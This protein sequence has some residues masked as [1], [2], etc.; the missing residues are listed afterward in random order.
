[1]LVWSSMTLYPA[2]LCHAD[3]DP[4]ANAT[5]RDTSRGVIW[6]TRAF[7]LCLLVFY[8]LLFSFLV[9]SQ[10]TVALQRLSTSVAQYSIAGYVMWFQFMARVCVS[11]CEEV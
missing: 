5:G 8:F 7:F 4:G 6:N 1:M 11:I 2:K 9:V 3:F 10:A